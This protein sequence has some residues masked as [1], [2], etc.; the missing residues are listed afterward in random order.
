LILHIK[1]MDKA[2]KTINTDAQ[3][4]I[5]I[6]FECR[7]KWLRLILVVY[8]YVRAVVVCVPL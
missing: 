3:K 4:N 7:Q 6:L 5:G 1:R 8:V 2:K